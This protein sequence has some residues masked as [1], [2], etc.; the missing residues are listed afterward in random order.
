MKW[1]PGNRPPHLPPPCHPQ[2]R[3]PHRRWGRGGTDCQAGAVAQLH[4]V[5]MNPVLQHLRG[6]RQCFVFLTDPRVTGLLCKKKKKSRHWPVLPVFLPECLPSSY[7][8]G[9]PLHQ[10][11]HLSQGPLNGPPSRSAPRYSP[12]T[13]ARG[14]FWIS[15]MHMEPMPIHEKNGPN[16][17]KKQ[18]PYGKKKCK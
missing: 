5:N 18:F 1:E 2:P 15:S 7:P 11:R 3:C 12:H 8:Q 9:P 16:N 13:S 17:M 14:V 10:A 6:S 4:P